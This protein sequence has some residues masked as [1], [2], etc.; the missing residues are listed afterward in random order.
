M[1]KPVDALILKAQEAVKVSIV[2]AINEYDATYKKE[3]QN[4]LNN[5]LMKVA[6]FGEKVGLKTPD[7]AYLYDDSGKSALKC[8]EIVKNVENS[9][10]L[11][12]N[13]NNSY[14]SSDYSASNDN[15]KANYTTS[16]TDDNH[17]TMNKD[18][19]NMTTPVLEPIDPDVEVNMSEYS[20]KSGLEPIGEVNYPRPIDAPTMLNMHENSVNLRKMA[21]F[22]RENNKKFILA[23]EQ[24][25][26]TH[27]IPS[28]GLYNYRVPNDNYVDYDTIYKPVV[29]AVSRAGYPVLATNPRAML[30]SF[31][32]GY[33][34]TEKYDNPN[35][36]PLGDEHRRSLPRYNGAIVGEEDSPRYYDTETRSYKYSYTGKPMKA[37]KDSEFMIN[38]GLFIHPG[39]HVGALNTENMSET[40]KNTVETS[41]NVGETVILADSA[42]N[43]VESTINN[44]N[45]SVDSN[46]TNDFT[47]VLN[48]DDKNVDNT[49]KMSENSSISAHEDSTTAKTL[50]ASEPS[51]TPSKTGASS[52]TGLFNK[53]LDE[54][55]WEHSSGS[56]EH[57]D[58]VLSNDFKQNGGFMSGKELL[59]AE[60]R[61]LKAQAAENNRSNTVNDNDSHV[62][63]SQ[64]EANLIDSANLGENNTA[65]LADMVENGEDSAESAENSQNKAEKAETVEAGAKTEAEK[66]PDYIAKHTHVHE[67][68]KVYVSNMADAEHQSPTGIYLEP[69]FSEEN[70]P[71]HS[72]SYENT[73]GNMC[74]LGKK[75]YEFKSTYDM[76]VEREAKEREA[77]RNAFK[78]V[79]RRV[80]KGQEFDAEK[81]YFKR[82]EHH[83]MANKLV[84]KEAYELLTKSAELVE[85]DPYYNSSLSTNLSP[86][87]IFNLI[88][89]N[90]YFDGD[91]I[92]TPSSESTI[93]DEL[94]HKNNL[95]VFLYV[96]I[97]D[98]VRSFEDSVVQKYENKDDLLNYRKSIVAAIK[99]R[100][101]LIT[102]GYDDIK[103]VHEYLI[104]M[105]IYQTKGDMTV[106]DK[107]TISTDD[108]ALGAVIPTELYGVFYAL[109]GILQKM[110]KFNKFFEKTGMNPA[111]M[112]NRFVA[113][114][115]DYAQKYENNIREL[116][117]N[118][119]K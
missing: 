12:S 34:I 35:N 68:G 114:H 42:N 45:V 14:S 65:K 20:Q 53:S 103:L 11:T 80:S 40:T 54:A 37:S 49:T 96:S 46:K 81:D 17:K 86:D 112:Y 92:L 47:T 108:N 59:E 18:D 5:I 50:E 33:F 82:Y 78:D 38:K 21:D 101:K 32:R 56:S 7:L 104:D 19:S 83:Y 58:S 3:L 102:G 109:S 99:R 77:Y 66:V 111:Q 79:F 25:T 118:S 27:E 41:E 15:I 93:L 76:R 89:Y 36:Y 105:A 60:N 13:T 115:P 69:M 71:A 23:D 57:L 6:K 95:F 8:P 67:D 1:D 116:V 9:T 75:P 22:C 62:E 87:T 61:V 91:H 73:Y 97:H 2:N 16:T 55:L 72:P 94:K 28:R 63:N 88:R 90:Q 31:A 70:E 44:A 119:G 113:K 106:E 110:L 24:M 4:E 48:A 64:N 98:Y 29:I 107:N 39:G 85:K 84:E 52:N 30:A 10:I 117:G 74:I 51:N 43:T 26:F 100:C